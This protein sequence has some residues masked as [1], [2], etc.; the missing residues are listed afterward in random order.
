M[1]IL[2]IAS[3]HWMPEGSTITIEVGGY[4]HEE[5]AA[6]TARLDTEF[7]TAERVNLGESDE[8]VGEAIDMAV[9]EKQLTPEDM[10]EAMYEFLEARGEHGKFAEFLQQYEK[11][12]TGETT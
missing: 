12:E 9:N 11:Q 5:F 1:R 8:T 6:L 3:A 10:V 4:N 7:L 2:R